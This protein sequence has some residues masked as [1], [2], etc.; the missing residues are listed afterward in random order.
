MSHFPWYL[1]C[2]ARN[3]K[4]T[5]LNPYKDWVY[6][7]FP[8]ITKKRKKIP[9][10]IFSVRLVSFLRQNHIGIFQQKHQIKKNNN[11]KNP[12]IS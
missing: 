10:G 3:T 6:D 11:P 5:P 2:A 1:F 12:I 9:F 7:L 4:K 8:K